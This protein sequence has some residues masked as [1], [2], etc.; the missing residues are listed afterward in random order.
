MHIHIKGEI[1]FNDFINVLRDELNENR[2]HLVNLAFTKLDING[3]GLLDPTELMEKYDAS[4]HPDVLTGRKTADQVLREWLTVF[5]V[6]GV[7]DGKVTFA[8][9]ENYY[10]NLGA[11][12]DRDD[13]FEL[14]IRNAWHISGGEG[15][16]AN[17]ANKR[18]LVTDNDGSQHVLEVKNDLGVTSKEGLFKRVRG[19]VRVMFYVQRY[20]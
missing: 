9:F 6:G 2:L 15:A 3:D 20:G 18:V 11:N 7:E 5:E 8:E 19:Y 12:I 1:N 10:T 4:Q 14:M 17:S 13:Y 16:A